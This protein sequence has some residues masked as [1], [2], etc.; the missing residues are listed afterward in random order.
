MAIFSTTVTKAND[1]STITFTDVFSSGDFNLPGFTATSATLTVYN[2][3][4]PSTTT[5]YDVIDDTTAG[6]YGSITISGDDLILNTSGFADGV[7]FFQFDYE[8]TDGSTI[9]ETVCPCMHIDCDMKTNITQA[10]Q[11]RFLNATTNCDACDEDKSLPIK[12]PMFHHALDI[13][14]DCQLCQKAIDIF[15]YIEL[16]VDDNDDCLGC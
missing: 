9:E 16:K 2:H 15:D 10:I 3:K 13:A 11:S 6:A 7:W 14:I 4:S 12:I 5:V 1:C 8:Y